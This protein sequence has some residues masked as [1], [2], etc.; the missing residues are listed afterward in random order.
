MAGLEFCLERRSGRS[1]DYPSKFPALASLLS[2]KCCRPRRPE[3][4]LPIGRLSL[5]FDRFVSIACAKVRAT[6]SFRWSSGSSKRLWSRAFWAA[7]RWAPAEFEHSENCLC[8]KGEEVSAPSV[9]AISWK[10]LFHQQVDVLLILAF[11]A[12]HP[13]RETSVSLHSLSILLRLTFQR[14]SRKL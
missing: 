11:V 1:F 3:T 8:W 12:F 5:R 4:I 6:W 2:R 7:A 9:I 10:I 13:Q 14:L